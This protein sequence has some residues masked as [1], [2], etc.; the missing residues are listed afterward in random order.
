MVFGVGDL[1]VVWASAFECDLWKRRRDSLLL[2]LISTP[3]I[4]SS[5]VLLHTKDVLF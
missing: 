4:C 2:S 1:E 5:T 3:A